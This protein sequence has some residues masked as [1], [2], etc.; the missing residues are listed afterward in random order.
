MSCPFILQP[1]QSLSDWYAFPSFILKAQANS[2]PALYDTLP[3]NPSSPTK[4]S[5]RGA[6][7]VLS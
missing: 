5:V 6:F 1:R 7:A 3:T 4:P 2:I